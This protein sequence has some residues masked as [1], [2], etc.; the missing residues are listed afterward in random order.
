MKLSRPTDKLAGWFGT[1]LI[2]IRAQEIKMW[3]DDAELQQ[4]RYHMMVISWYVPGIDIVGIL[5]INTDIIFCMLSVCN[6]KHSSAIMSSVLT[7]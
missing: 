7:C 1:D 5:S 2:K 4:I 6:P 3:Q